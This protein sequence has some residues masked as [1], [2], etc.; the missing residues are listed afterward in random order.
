MEREYERE[1]KEA[2]ELEAPPKTKTK[3]TRK[4][5]IAANRQDSAE[6]YN[7]ERLP[8]EVAESLR[9]G[10]LSFRQ[11]GLL[12]YIIG[13]IDWTRGDYAR[14]LV[15]F[16]A[17]IGWELSDETLRADLA[18]L[19]QQGWI[20]FASRQG[21]R[22]AYSFRLGPRVFKSMG[23]PEYFPTGGVEFLEVSSKR[24]PNSNGANP[25]PESIN[26]SSQPPSSFPPIDTDARNRQ[27][28]DGDRKPANEEIE[29]N[30][31]ACRRVADEVQKT[32]PSESRSQ[33]A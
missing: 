24:S 29:G 14:T 10:E 9:R 13:S 21:Q 22:S 11:H 32:L 17:D 27:D 20:T 8:C 1:K 30:E 16:M 12:T 33:L 3:K 18:D 25:H 28:V 7:F 23:L 31:E 6:A 26:G 19:K 4:Q 5:K 2:P 15:A